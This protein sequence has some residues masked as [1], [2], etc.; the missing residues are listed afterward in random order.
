MAQLKAP[1]LVDYQKDMLEKEK[2][3]QVAEPPG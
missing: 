1:E 2:L 3:K